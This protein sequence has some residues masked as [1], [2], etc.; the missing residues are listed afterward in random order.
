MWR[1][2]PRPATV[3]ASP[4]GI[5]VIEIGSGALAPVLRARPMLQ[6]VLDDLIARRQVER[7]E[8]D[9]LF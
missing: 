2:E 4:P 5:E 9:V 1:G 8:N 6:D 3:I 7:R